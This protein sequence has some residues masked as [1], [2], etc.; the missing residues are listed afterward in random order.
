MIYAFDSYYRDGDCQ[1]IGVGFSGWT[2]GEAGEIYRTKQTIPSEYVPGEFYK[3]ELPGIL[4]LIRKIPLQPGDIL[5]VDGYVHLDDAGKLGLGGH[6]HQ[7]LGEEYPVIGVAKRKFRTINEL[8]IGVTRGKSENPLFV[9]AAGA[10][11]KLAAKLVEQM[12]G[13]YRMPT[14]LKKV[15]ALSRVQ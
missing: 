3:R 9:T 2:T 10:D 7:Q 1:T 13:P 5:I 15:D 11:L 12:H 14:I 6:L 8:T 4:D